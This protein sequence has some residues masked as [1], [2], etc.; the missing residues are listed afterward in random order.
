MKT[1]RLFTLLFLYLC[2]FQFGLSQ[3][4]TPAISWSNQSFWPS[5]ESAKGGF[6]IIDENRYVLVSMVGKTLSTVQLKLFDKRNLEKVITKKI[7]LGNRGKRRAFHQISLI[8][9]QLHLFTSKY[10]KDGISN[11]LYKQ[12][13]SVVDLQVGAM[14]KIAKSYTNGTHNTFG[15][16]LSKDEKKVLTYSVDNF[17]ESDPVRVKIRVFDERFQPIWDNKYLLPFENKYYKITQNVIDNLGN[18]YLIGDHAIGK[19]HKK[20]QGSVFCLKADGSAKEHRFGVAKKFINDLEYHIDQQGNL[21]A[22]GTFTGVTRAGDLFPIIEGIYLF[23]HNHQTDKFGQRIIYFESNEFQRNNKAISKKGRFYNRLYLKEGFVKRDNSILLALEQIKPANRA[24]N[25]AIRGT[26]EWRALVNNTAAFAKDVYTSRTEDLPPDGQ[27]LKYYKDVVL[28]NIKGFKVDWVRNIPKKQR[29]IPH[30]KRTAS[31]TAVQN[32]NDFYFV[33]ND[34]KLNQDSYEL[35]TYNQLKTHEQA[36][37]VKKLDVD[38]KWT[39]YFPKLPVKSPFPICTTMSKPLS[40]K[41][42]LLFGDFGAFYRF[43]SLKL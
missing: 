16:N 41:E 11:T 3:D 4:T 8:G 2:F 33:Y 19:S 35:N 6:V 18:V 24:G 34:T 32:G 9:K 13:I 43:G 15:I 26:R 31:Y 17:I 28:V 39:T 30:H 38:G 40:D 23:Q 7:P 10:D 29:L 14:K 21:V 25:L 22:A 37:V 5:P 27:L 12:A 20:H 42:L 36:V 1:T